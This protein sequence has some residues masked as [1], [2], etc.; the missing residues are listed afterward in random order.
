VLWPGGKGLHRCADEADLLA[1]ELDLDKKAKL[2]PTRKT[3]KWV[4]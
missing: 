4:E 1:E 2:M 3:K